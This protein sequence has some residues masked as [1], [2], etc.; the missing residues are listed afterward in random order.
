MK[1]LIQLIRLEF[2]PDWDLVSKRYLL[3]EIINQDSHVLI[4]CIWTSNNFDFYEFWSISPISFSIQITSNIFC[5]YF[6]KLP[7]TM[8]IKRGTSFTANPIHY[9]LES[10]ED[11]SPALLPI[12]PHSQ[13]FSAFYL[14]F[15]VIFNR[16]CCKK[17]WF[18]KL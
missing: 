18:W 1:N 7:Y 3:K 16:N 9:L 4:F 17:C 5:R 11:L 10:N 14:N 8:K 2:Q 12:P 15:I 6:C 13:D